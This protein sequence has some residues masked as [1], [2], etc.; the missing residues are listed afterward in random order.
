MSLIPGKRM[1]IPLSGEAVISG[2]ITLI[3]SETGVDLHIPQELKK[4]SPPKTASEAVDFGYT[5]V[6]TDTQG[7]RYG[8]RFGAI[9]T[10]STETRHQKMEKRHKL[11]ALAKKKSSLNTKRAK[12]LRKYNLGKKKQQST[13]QSFQNTLE[14]EINAAINQLVQT[15]NPSIVITE[16]LRHAFSHNKGKKMN[17]KLSSWLKGKLQDRVAFKALAEGF[18]HEQVNPAYGSQSC[19]HCEFVDQRNR[20]K[21]RFQYLHCGH[22]D[23]SDRIAALNYARRF[24]DPE[25]GLYTPYRHVKTILLDRFH[26]RLEMEQSMTVPGRTLETVGEMHPPSLSRC[27]VIAGRKKFRKPDGQSE[28]ETNNKHV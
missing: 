14:K 20:S 24:G 22:E 27:N 26:R 17:R 19:P 12:K 1:A 18:R 3:L 6:M 23:I 8:A 2:T 4:K 11:H 28:S 7:I 10:Q 25:I 15:K 16:D 13:T 9:L 5:E 21:D